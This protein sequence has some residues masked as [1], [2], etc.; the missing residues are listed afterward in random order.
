MINWRHAL[1]R[2]W[3]GLRFGEVKIE[4]AAQQHTYELQVF[5][6]E[7]EPDAVRLE[8][9]AEGDNENGPVRQEMARVRPLVG[10]VNGFV[11]RASV[12]ATRPATDYTPRIVPH[13][14]RAAVPLEASQIL[15]QR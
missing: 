9:Y 3:A 11:Y 8:L 5:L 10:S 6:D 7:I 14:P 4:S 1:E 15:W 12:P 2:Q 13:F